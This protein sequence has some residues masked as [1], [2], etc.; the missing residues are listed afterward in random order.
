MPEKGLFKKPAQ[1]DRALRKV[2]LLMKKPGG[3]TWPKRLQL[4]SFSEQE[5]LEPAAIVAK[6]LAVLAGTTYPRLLA[7]QRK[8]K[9][10]GLNG[11]NGKS[12]ENPFSK[13]P[14]HLDFPAGKTSP[15]LKEERRQ[16][17]T[18]LIV[19]EKEMSI[20]DNSVQIQIL[21]LLIAAK[22]EGSS[23][24]GK[25]LLAL[26]P[27]DLPYIKKRQRLHTDIFRLKRELKNQGLKIVGQGSPRKKA[28]MTTYS[29]VEQEPQ[30]TKNVEPV[31]IPIVPEQK[32]PPPVKKPLSIEDLPN[33][34]ADEAS[35]YS[36]MFLE[37]ERY[38]KIATMEID[39]T[40]MIV[41]RLMTTDALKQTNRPPI[42]LLKQFAPENTSIES[43]LGIE[44]KTELEEYFIE[45][46]T[47]TIEKIWNTKNKFTL[48]E[49]EQRI[50]EN[51]SSLRKGGYDKEKIVQL[52]RM[53]FSIPTPIPT[54]EKA[55]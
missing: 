30:S 41:S 36:R 46:I 32:S 5:L 18:I 34:I 35:N 22:K 27:N 4:S 29:L 20:I 42:E 33:N 13:P 15:K 51:L 49:K 50:S 3:S 55:N 6:A 14:S 39:L 43:L 2:S 31:E 40:R 17:H 25:D 10:A 44:S 9:Q 37:A 28:A 53:L 54:E 21:N 16:K 8:I 52:L 26:Y 38:R 11:D 48:S 47:R 24:S 1:I 7:E 19:D 12:M 45:S 23:V